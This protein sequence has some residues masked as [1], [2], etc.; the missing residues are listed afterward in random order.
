MKKNT[1]SSPRFIPHAPEEACAL[2]VDLV[3]S[4]INNITSNIGEKLFISHNAIPEKKVL[5][6]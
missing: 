1:S 4:K 3:L 6:T 2:N 5:S